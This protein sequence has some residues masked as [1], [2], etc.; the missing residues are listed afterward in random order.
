M[1]QTR[2]TPTTERELIDLL[3]SLRHIHAELDDLERRKRDLRKSFRITQ[4][5]A[6]PK[7]TQNLTQNRGLESVV[8]A[9]EKLEN[10]FSHLTLTL[11]NRTIFIEAL[12]R[13]LKPLQRQIIRQRYY[14][15]LEWP[16]IAKSGHMS[17]R[18]VYRVHKMALHDMT[19]CDTLY[20]GRQ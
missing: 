15:G 17:L 9:L 6:G 4:F 7:S 11:I 3:A 8:E 19:K 18:T 1:T 14:D 10:E 12:L 2:P 13:R 16:S 5:D 20:M